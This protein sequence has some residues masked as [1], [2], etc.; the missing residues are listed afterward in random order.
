MSRPLRVLFVDDSVYDCMLLVKELRHGGFEP[1]YAR[2]DTLAAMKMELARA[3]WALVL[4]DASI[5]ELDVLTVIQ[6]VR[7]HDPDLPVIVIS[8]VAGGDGA[9]AALKAGASDYLQRDRLDKLLAT[10]ERELRQSE[11]CRARK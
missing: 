5:L 11:E 2:A 8:E 1:R 7:D 4:V 6:A 3:A 10:V 9:V